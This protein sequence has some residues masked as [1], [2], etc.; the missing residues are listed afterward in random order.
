MIVFSSSLVTAAQS[1]PAID[2]NAPIFGYRSYVTTTTV[3]ATDAATGYPATNLANVS[4]AEFWK[5]LNATGTKYLTVTPVVASSLDYIAVAGH[6][7]GSAQIAVRVEARTTSTGAWT[8]IVA[9]FMPTND[10]ALI[11][12]FTETVYHSIR[13]RLAAG[14]APAQAAVLYTGLLLVS[15]RRAYVGVAPITLNRRKQ[16][17]TGRSEAGNFLGRIETGSTLQTSLAL[18]YLTPDWYRANMDPFIDAASST[19]FFF[20]WR[21]Q[22][23][24][25]ECAFCWLTGDPTPENQMSNGMMQVTLEMQGAAA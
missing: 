4:T 3:A 8:V 18:N 6:N 2:L 9:E 11:L 1:N 24:P 17:V 22:D 14:S 15:Q 13:L 23:Y 7:F 10:N 21:P 12:R 25:N 5:A 16:S 20:G 19:P